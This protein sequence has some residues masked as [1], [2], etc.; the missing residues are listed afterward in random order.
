MRNGGIMQYPF[1]AEQLA[2]YTCDFMEREVAPV[3]T[4]LR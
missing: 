1:T 4:P 3:D 2:Q